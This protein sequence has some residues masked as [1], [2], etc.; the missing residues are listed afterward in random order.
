M[1]NNRK[2]LLKNERKSVCYGKLRKRKQRLVKEV[3][4][5]GGK[6]ETQVERKSKEKERNYNCIHPSIHSSMHWPT[7][8]EN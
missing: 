4:R 7:E 5:G 3:K 6:E 2:D 8:M 1:L